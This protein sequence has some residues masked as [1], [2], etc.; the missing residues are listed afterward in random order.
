MENVNVKVKE[1]ITNILLNGYLIF[2]AY[3]FIVHINIDNIDLLTNKFV[4]IPYINSKISVQQHAIISIFTI[5]IFISVV[6]YYL[7]K[8]TQLPFLLNLVKK[9]EIFY[10]LF[11]ISGFL[12]ISYVFNNLYKAVKWDYSTTITMA[13]M[14]VW[15]GCISFFLLKK[16][17]YKKERKVFRCMIL[18]AFVAAITINCLFFDHKIII[19][20]ITLTDNISETHIKN[21]EFHNVKFS[22][23]T[24]SESQ[25]ENVHFT[26]CIFDTTYFIET[27]FKSC[28]FIKKFN[29]KYQM[30]DNIFTKCYFENVDLV[31]SPK[32]DIIFRSCVAQCI[33]FKGSN[34]DGINI[35]ESSNFRYSLNLDP[36]SVKADSTSSLPD[37]IVPKIEECN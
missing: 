23:I 4:L 26:T 10:I 32:L 9:S 33:D 28:K 19:R 7:K 34:T 5:I 15:L 21:A 35:D 17:E 31:N 3:A 12:V 29:L 25:F 27:D 36:D 22:K 18:I 6:E 14:V 16:R 11:Y 37:S 13:L 1:N 30:E 2:I 24:F 20:N 8:E